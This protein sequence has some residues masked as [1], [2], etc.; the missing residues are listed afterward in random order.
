MTKEE[1]YL[2]LLPQ[3][4]SLLSDES[5]PIAR[6]ANLAALLHQFVFRKERPKAV[7]AFFMGA[8]M[9]V[10]HMYAVFITHRNDVTKSY[11][12]VRVCALP[13]ILFTGIGL[14][15]CSITVFMPV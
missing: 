4:Q 5:D 3:M 13:M 9:E 7:Y 11:E 8:V 14:A 10:F 15:M 2:A 12:V 6:M 1:K